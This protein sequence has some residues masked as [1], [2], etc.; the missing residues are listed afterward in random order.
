MSPR[1]G[2]PPSENP[3][4]NDTRIRMS[5][6]DVKKLDYCCKVF[7]LTKADVIRLG[8]KTVYESTKRED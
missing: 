5:D 8:I 3:K 2:R 7:G 6:E 1:T 4:K